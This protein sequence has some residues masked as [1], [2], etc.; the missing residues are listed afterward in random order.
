MTRPLYFDTRHQVHSGDPLVKELLQCTPLTCT[1]ILNDTIEHIVSAV[2]KIPS[3]IVEV[4]GSTLQELLSDGEIS[5]S[6][7]VGFT[8]FDKDFFD[9]Y[10]DLIRVFD[11]TRTLPSITPPSYRTKFF[12]SQDE[13]LSITLDP[14]PDITR[15]FTVLNAFGKWEGEWLQQAFLYAQDNHGEMHLMEV[16]W[17]ADWTPTEWQSIEP[18]EP[19]CDFTHELLNTPTAPPYLALDIY[20]T[21]WNISMELVGMT[22]SG[23]EISWTYKAMNED[24]IVLKKTIFQQGII[25]AG[26]WV[27]GRPL[28]TPLGLTTRSVLEYLE[29]ITGTM[30][31]FSR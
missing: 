19:L 25:A 23:T 16:L 2:I 12:V 29:E 9:I 14:Y 7:V 11:E 27:N 3:E 10:A 4:D 13:L 1:R 31:L 18:S 28:M 30:A 20:E 21:Y 26:V 6:N 5:L 15:V 8:L 17:E 22:S 24:E